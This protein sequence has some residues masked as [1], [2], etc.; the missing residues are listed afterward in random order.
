MTKLHLKRLAAPKTWPILRKNTKWITKPSPGPH[1]QT[2]ALPLSVLIKEVLTLTN[3][4]QELRQVIKKQA[5]MIDG[6]PASSPKFPVGYLDVVSIPEQQ[7]TYRMVMDERGRLAAITIPAAEAT[8]KLLQVRT[9]T[10]IGKDALQIGCNDGT[11]LRVAANTHYKIG[12]SVLFDLKERRVVEHL[13]LAAKSCCQVLRGHHAGALGIVSAVTGQQVH[14]S[15]D[16]VEITTDKSNCFV[17]GIEKPRIS[18]APQHK[19][20]EA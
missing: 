20:K 17:L 10:S 12:D 5:I 18:V 16:K 1:D 2:M 9:K 13:P 6:K 15:V 4:T 8:V 19:P 7:A 11:T 3:T 14:L